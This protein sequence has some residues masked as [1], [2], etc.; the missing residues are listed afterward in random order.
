M[1]HQVALT[2]LSLSPFHPLSPAPPAISHPGQEHVEEMISVGFPFPGWLLSMKARLPG[3]G[4]KAFE[5]SLS[6]WDPGHIAIGTFTISRAA[7]A[8]GHLSS[9]N[10][11]LNDAQGLDIEIPL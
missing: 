8:Q 4:A 7:L 11:E 1:G 3:P 2:L 5:T 10:Q 9:M 6:F